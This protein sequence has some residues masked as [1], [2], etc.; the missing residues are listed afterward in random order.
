MQPRQLRRKVHRVEDNLQ[1]L[2]RNLPMLYL[3]II[4][5]FLD[6]LLSMSL[7]RISYYT[8]SL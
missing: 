3:G 1:H 8:I 2:L 6:F 4:V 7:G 5:V